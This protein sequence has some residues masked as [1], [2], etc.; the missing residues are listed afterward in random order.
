[1]RD[2]FLINSEAE[3]NNFFTISNVN[4]YPGSQI[5]ISLR[6]RDVQRQIRYIP[7]NTSTLTAFFNLTDGTEL[8]KAMTLI[9]ADDR[10]MWT[11]TLTG[12]ETEDLVGGNIRLELDELGTETEIQ[13]ILI[14]GAL[15]KS[16]AGC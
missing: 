13:I 10:S 1:M 16:T 12:A 9:D 15:A 6:L 4:F 5:Q 11:V 2:A 7:L 8:E 3:L 14:P